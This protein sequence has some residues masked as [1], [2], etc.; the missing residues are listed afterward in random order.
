MWLSDSFETTEVES[1]YGGTDKASFHG[2]VAN[3]Q[4]VSRPQQ[5][6]AIFRNDVETRTYGFDQ[7]LAHANDSDD[8]ALFYDTT[9]EDIFVGRAHMSSMIGPVFDNRAVGFSVVTAY[10]SG[11]AFDRA[12]LYDS[13]GEDTFVGRAQ[14][15]N[16]SGDGFSNRTFG[17][18]Q[19]KGH[20][21]GQA[22]DVA[23]LFDS[24]HDDEFVS[25]Q[26][27]SVMRRADSSQNTMA[28][29]FGTVHGHAVEG[30]YDVA[31]FKDVTGDESLFGREDYA[32]LVG[33]DA[34]V[35]GFDLVVAETE[36]GQTADA[37]IVNVDYVFS[38]FGTWT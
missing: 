37:D 8:R 9:G 6:M 17:F 2:T 1:R 21:S 24:A 20:S 23:V 25:R 12:L 11:D 27:F 15:A 32:R 34:L 29:G 38:L 18:E 14:N 35:T 3:D 7:N 30:G 31:M 22:G 28:I 26:G 10:A 5:Q 13:A 19:V 33:R 4:F 16:L 36:S